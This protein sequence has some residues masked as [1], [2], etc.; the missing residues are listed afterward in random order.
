MQVEFIHLFKQR[1]AYNTGHP[2]GYQSEQR[3]GLGLTSLP[4]APRTV[5]DTKLEH[6]DGTIL[7]SRHDTDLLLYQDAEKRKNPGVSM[8]P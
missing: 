3:T 8:A 5:N 2:L 7:I 6:S 1:N 4:L